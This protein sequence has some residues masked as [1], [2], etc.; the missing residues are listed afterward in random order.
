MNPHARMVEDDAPLCSPPTGPT[1]PTVVDP[2][3]N[4]VQARRRL[5][6]I[7]R[8][9][10]ASRSR[11]ATTVRQ[12]VDAHGRLRTAG[13]FLGLVVLSMIC[14][15]VI[16]A[17]FASGQARADEL[18]ARSTVTV[19]IGAAPPT[20]AVAVGA[21]ADAAA[22]FVDTTQ[23]AIPGARPAEGKPTAAFPLRKKRSKSARPS[24]RTQS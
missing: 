8:R 16:G 9:G 10:E 3:G 18:A 22:P 23:A 21:S 5:H 12:R 1:P 19:G 2:W 7:E 11:S 24:P 4:G 20:T 17:V 13:A 15:A 14:A 6:V